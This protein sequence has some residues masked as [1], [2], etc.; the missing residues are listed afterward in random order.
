[1]EKQ[2]KQLLTVATFFSRL[3]KF[4][5]LTVIFWLLI[6]A[7][8]KLFQ[9][10]LIN[11]SLLSFSNNF[12]FKY[13]LGYL[14]IWKILRS[15]GYLMMLPFLILLAIIF[16]ITQRNS[17]KINQKYKHVFLSVLKYFILLTFSYAIV[18]FLI[19]II[20]FIYHITYEVNHVIS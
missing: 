6:S 10:G 7:I 5:T 19:D 11:E 12:G 20:Y 1:M 2:I 18:A 14:P 4:Y 15:L 17:S 9:T 3:L 13:L 16:F 8:T